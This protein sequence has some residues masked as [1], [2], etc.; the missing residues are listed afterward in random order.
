MRSPRP[1]WNP[2]AGR[3]SAPCTPRI[4]SSGDRGMTKVGPFRGSRCL[5]PRVPE[6]A[7]PPLAGVVAQGLVDEFV[8]AGLLVADQAIGE[9]GLEVVRRHSALG[10]DDG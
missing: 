7:P 9:V 6:R 8:G 2:G 1:R 3:F 5:Q 10:L 4:A